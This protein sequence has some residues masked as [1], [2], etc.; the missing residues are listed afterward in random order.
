M[1]SGSPEDDCEDS[2]FNDVFTILDWIDE[3][4]AEEQVNRLTDEEPEA[5]DDEATE[6][7]EMG[8]WPLEGEDDGDE[9]D[10]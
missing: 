6:C 3:A 8:D 5:D 9:D 7:D 10:G 2:A 4:A 1:I